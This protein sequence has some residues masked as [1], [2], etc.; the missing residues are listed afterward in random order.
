MQAVKLSFAELLKIEGNIEHYHIPKYQR[1]Y[2]WGRF[3]WETL[4][5]DIN[6]NSAD[7]FIGSVIVVGNSSDLR[8][9]EE[10]IYQVIDGQQR[11]TTLSIFLAAIYF[12]YSTWS[13]TVEVD[14]ED[15]KNEYTI[16]LD[17]IRRKLLKKKKEIY[18]NEI[19][20]FK[21]GNFHCFL[22]VQ[23]ST[24]NLNLADYKLILK[25][26]GLLENV[27]VP[28]FFGLRRFSKAFDFFF[29][30]L[31]STKEELDILL[32]KINRLVFIHISVGTQADAFTLFETLNNRGV[33]LSPIDIIKNSLL[34]EMEKQH[35]QEIDTSYDNW[36]LLLQYLPDFDNQ[37]RF[38]RQFYNAF[39]IDEKIKQERITRA[40]KSN[41]LQI[42]ESLIKKNAKF[43]FE[44]LLAKGEYYGK[45]IGT[46]SSENADFNLKITELNRV[47]AA[48]S[49]TLLLYLLTNESKFAEGTSMNQI[50]D[51][52]IKYYVRRNITDTPNTRDLD[53]VTIE[54]IEKCN[55][56]LTENKK[57]DLETIRDGH[58][59]NSKAK[60]ASL[61][62][63]KKWLSDKVYA[64]NVGMTRY[65]LWKLD[66]VK[67]TKEYSPDLWQRNP[68]NDT[69]VW[70]IEHIFPEGENIPQSWVEMIGNGDVVK[71]REIQAE[72]VHI[73]GNLT[74]SAYNSNLSNRP[75]LDKQLLSTRKV[76]KDELT[77]GYKNG[78]SLNN[79]TFMLDNKEFSL[80][81]IEKWNVDTIE[82][83][84]KSMVE[85]LTNIF[86]FE[87][88]VTV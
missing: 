37:S 29:S 7:Y 44:E 47:G 10:K 6:E 39:K 75:F 40:T 13:K 54:V 73:L 83:R 53:A 2:V 21:N 74:L 26:C 23:P 66:S 78:L 52:L 28:K 22:R 15:T 64:N 32:D 56:L 88:E 24:Q 30:Q 34:A 27:E 62:E 35:G 33:D 18:P 11:L 79:L 63:F 58:I 17:S 50:I 46:V 71:A 69:F 19:G 31:P 3:H 60:P 36:Q 45:L 86:K 70:T 72:L 81:T 25:N 42:Y 57:I 5:N 61:E 20:G 55:A 8:P 43:T 12:K 9:G 80:S 41:I 1:E 38:L 84:T 65:L 16:K 59:N 87:N 51:F 76:G 77:I 4:V 14:D 67:H 82:A 49:Y 85:K 48:A 68:N